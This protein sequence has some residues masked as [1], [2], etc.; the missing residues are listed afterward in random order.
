MR[1]DECRALAWVAATEVDTVYARAKS[2]L[3]FR[4]T[5]ERWRFAEHHSFG[6]VDEGFR[7]T[8]QSG[9]YYGIA[10]RILVAGDSVWLA[11]ELVR[12]GPRRTLVSGKY[13]VDTRHPLHG[14]RQFHSQ[15]D[16]S[17]RAA[18]R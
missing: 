2:K 9:A 1:T 5:E 3:R 13:C 12:D 14:D 17:L 16:R 8:A 11:M 10:D 18:L 4:T 15:I 7:H 6:W